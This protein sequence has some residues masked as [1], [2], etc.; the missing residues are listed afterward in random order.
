MYVA[1]IGAISG[2]GSASSG[3]FYLL[4]SN[5]GIAHPVLILGGIIAWA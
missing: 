1:I 5:L 2:Q 3:L 4:V